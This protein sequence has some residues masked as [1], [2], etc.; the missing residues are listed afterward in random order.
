MLRVVLWIRIG[1]SADPDTDPDPAFSLKREHFS[2]QNMNF[3]TFV[4]YFGPPGTHC[5]SG[6]SQPKWMWIHADPDPQYWLRVGIYCFEKCFE[7]RLLDRN[8]FGPF[9]NG[10]IL[11]LRPAW[12]TGREGWRAAAGLRAGC[13]TGRCPGYPRGSPWRI[14]PE[15]SPRL[16]LRLQWFSQLD[17]IHQQ[18]DA[19]KYS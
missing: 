16:H 9:L 17:G 14:P 7:L 4:G 3:F 12:N 13:R 15:W 2:L 18:K 5:G 8:K 6:F 1:F 10:F 19:K 11:R